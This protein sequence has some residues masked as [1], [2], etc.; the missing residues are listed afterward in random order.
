VVRHPA[1]SVLIRV[2]GEN[3]TTSNTRR[4]SAPRSA[5][6]PA[7][8]GKAR[9]GEHAFA[10]LLAGLIE[11]LTQHASATTTEPGGALWN[12][13]SAVSDGATL[14]RD[15]ASLSLS[16]VAD[17]IGTSEFFGLVVGGYIGRSETGMA[18]APADP[19]TGVETDR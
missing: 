18:D 3:M 19:A 7:P 5:A 6:K 15:D 11:L 14:W 16:P 4:P 8:Q 13:L 17:L 10:D 2:H 9:G 12:A 1:F